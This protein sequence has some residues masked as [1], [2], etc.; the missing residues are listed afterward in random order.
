MRN[1]IFLWMMLI[2]GAPVFGQVNF[3]AKYSDAEKIYPYTDSDFFQNQEQ[4]QRILRKNGVVTVIQ[5]GCWYGKSTICIAKAIPAEGKI[6]AIDSW[7]GY[8]AEIYRDTFHAFE[9]FV[10]NVTHEGVE[11]KI[12]PIRMTSLQANRLLRKSV[13]S[14]DMIYLDADHSYDAVLA[15]LKAWSPY[16]KSGGIF[17]GNAYSKNGETAAILRAVKE[18]ARENGRRLVVNGYFWRLR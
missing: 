9:R 8:P 17:C 5:V 10:S 12:V 15:D 2:A 1:W 4:L 11:H 3:N 13:N 14:V 7:I 16:L 18:F 6:Y